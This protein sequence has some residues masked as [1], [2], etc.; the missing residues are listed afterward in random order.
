MSILT[1][2]ARRA[3]RGTK[4]VELLQELLDQLVKSKRLAKWLAN[5]FTYIVLAVD[6][7]LD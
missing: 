3:L 6:I 7:N 4:G 2:Q 1:Y 5:M